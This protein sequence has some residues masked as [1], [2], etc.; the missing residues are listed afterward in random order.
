MDNKYQTHQNLQGQEAKPPDQATGKGRSQSTQAAAWE[1]FSG[2][3]GEEP[4]EIP[5]FASEP[6]EAQGGW[7]QG[8]GGT[9]KAGA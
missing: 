3:S 4:H 8:E 7:E 6:A 9:G 1:R 5:P 2:F